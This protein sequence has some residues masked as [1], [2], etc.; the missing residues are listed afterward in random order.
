MENKKI[1]ENIQ[2]VKNILLILS[3]KGGVGKTSTAVN[4]AYGLALQNYKVGILDIDIHGPNVAKMLGVDKEKLGSADGQMEPVKVL[5]N[6]KVVSI[7]FLLEK[8]ETPV[9]WRGPLKMKI[10]NQFLGETNWGNL[11]FLIIDNPPG[12]GDEPL[13]ACQLITNIDGAIIVTTPQE[14]ALLDVRKSIV[15]AKELKVPV[16]GIIEN[17]SYLTCPNCKHKIF[18][19]GEGGGEKIEK[20]F[21]TELLGKIPFDTE[22]PKN[23]DKGKPIFV[24][25]SEA[26]KVFEKIIEKIKKKL[27]LSS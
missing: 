10:I 13:S 14:I 18:L 24:S 12:T 25:E 26:K 27:G 8:T 9:I 2:N 11:D 1:Q 20:E 23:A 15:F 5:P 3:G 21:G 7:S 19:F 16:L 17:M 22:I 4:L 6:L